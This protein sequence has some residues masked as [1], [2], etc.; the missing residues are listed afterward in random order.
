[1]KK[2]NKAILAVCLSLCILVCGICPAF[3]AETEPQEIHITEK[4]EFLQFV[5]AC[6]LDSYSKNLVVELETDVDL[7]DVNF[8]GI[9]IF[10]GEFRGNGH[11]ISGISLQEEG[12]VQGL[13]RY[14]TK[15]ALVQDLSV[16][17]KVSPEGSRATVGG[18][19]GSNSGTI[20][21]CT[22]TGQVSGG[23]QIGGIVGVNT[24]SGL[25]E[26]SQV[27]G[28]VDG[29]HF[30]G[31]ITGENAG[32]VRDCRNEAQV[33]VTADQNR[34]DLADV[35]LHTLTGTESTRTTTDIGGIAGTSSGVVRSCENHGTVGYQHMGYNVGGIAGSQT[36]LIINCANFSTVNGRKEVGG[37]VGQI[38]PI[39]HIEYGKD[40]L[41]ILQ[42][43][44][45]KTASLADQAA[46]NVK[47][48]T[49]AM[50]DQV[51]AM[52]G[53][54]GTAVDAIDQLVPDKDNPHLPDEDGILAAKN[55]LNSSVSAMNGTMDG[56]V[57][58]AHN[59]ATTLAGDVQAM[60]KQMEAISKT[61]DNASANLGG[62]MTDVSDKDTPDD[63][64]G[65]VAQCANTG[66]V[67]GDL[68][69]GGIA[70][71]VAW[72]NDLDPEDDLQVS[73]NRSLHFK[74]ELRAVVRDCENHAVISAKKRQ[75]GGIVGWLACGLVKDSTNTGDL[76]AE[77][78]RQVGGIAGNSA[79]FIRGCN[80]KC[81]LS[82]NSSVGGIAG[83]A[84]IA[85]DCRSVVTIQDG[86]EKLG[87]VLGE[88]LTGHEE[89]TNPI[90]RNWYLVTDQDFGGI[91]GISYAEIAQPMERD[92][93]L[94]LENLP[95]VFSASTLTFRQADGTKI[96]VQVPLGEPLEEDA[97]PA[98]TEENGQIGSWDGLEETDRTHIYFDHTYPAEY[99]TYRTTL[100]SKQERDNG[101]A[102]L[103]AEGEF[104]HHDQLPLETLDD[105]PTLQEGE[106]LLESWQIPHF[107]DE[108]LTR[109]RVAC[110]ED[111]DSNHIQVQLR[112]TE[113]EWRV[114]DVQKNGQY[115]VFAVNA[116]DDGFCLVAQPGQTA[117]IVSGAACGGALL[118]LVLILGHS[119][120]K[121][122]K[123]KQNPQKR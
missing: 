27:E 106:T 60:A 69:V 8:A 104:C 12:S 67:D 82:G 9:P 58:S 38:E 4:A 19:A 52:Q 42:Q 33:N 32:T 16:R 37:I 63:L 102:V 107:E 114:A 31:G 2:T 109:L 115:L 117:W 39:P 24:V 48:S 99:E 7:S 83:G 44:M 43:Q 122:K 105:Q 62:S 120:R 91:D 45:K 64:T 72:E 110:P 77:N 113:G 94:Q 13:F 40:T 47:N 50:Q 5:E 73:G 78:A 46:A 57:E 17:G 29:E 35:S 85:T 90:A 96:P 111:A 95:E 74:G 108:K 56:M 1:M 84:V 30:V 51:N 26:S 66:A 10:C 89:E 55:T 100:R 116:E 93:F 118:L 101:A 15:T 76:D 53:Y 20:R 41:Q 34:V 112:S 121:R 25:I 97:V 70:G 23:R 87:A 86:T 88:Q 6:R 75:V 71:A 14:L 119:R 98:V 18:I 3:A 79:G 92:A 61:L 21:N 80:A 81:E 123:K 22:F 103:L 68:N 49:S 54:A 65:K 36:G 59:T 11:T 28:S